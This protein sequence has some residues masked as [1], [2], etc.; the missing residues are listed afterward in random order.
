[1]NRFCVPDLLCI[2]VLSGFKSNRSTLSSYSMDI[3]NYT[4]EDKIV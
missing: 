4:N 3:E 1:M 2:K